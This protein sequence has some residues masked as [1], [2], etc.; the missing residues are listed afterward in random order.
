MN[1]RS[2]RLIFKKK[3]DFVKHK[4]RESM[5]ICMY[6]KNINHEISTFSKLFSAWNGTNPDDV[7]LFSI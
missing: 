1:E 7:I 6:P 3:I 4:I 5:E 2:I